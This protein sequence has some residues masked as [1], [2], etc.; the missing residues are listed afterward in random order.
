VVAAA[1]LHHRREVLLAQ[2]AST[3]SI[4]PGKCHL[5]GGHVEFG[6]HPA[7][8]LAREL[9]EELAIET[10]AHEPL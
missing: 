10:V 6:E 2:R 3:K 1:F 8:A 7:T 5:P 4:A 9:R